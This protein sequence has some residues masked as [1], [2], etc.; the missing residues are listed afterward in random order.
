M[1][2]H[3]QLASRLITLLVILLSIA[4]I[5][6]LFQ[7]NKL[8]D[9]QRLIRQDYLEIG[10]ALKMLASSSN[11]QTEAARGYAATGDR[12]HLNTYRIGITET[13]VREHVFE[14]LREIG[15]QAAEM[16]ALEHGGRS[17]HALLELERQALDAASQGNHAGALAILYSPVYLSHKT[18]S[19]SAVDLATAILD[20]RLG[21]QIT[22]LES[23]IDQA[24]KLMLVTTTSSV[25]VIMLALLG[26]YERRVVNPVIRITRQTQRLL[27]GEHGVGF[28]H[29]KDPVEI[30]ELA[31]VLDDYHH[32]TVQLDAQRAEQQAILDTATSGIVLV[33]DD[34]IIKH[35]NHKLH[36][37]FDW[38][39]GSMP[40]LSTRIWYPDEAGWEAGGNPVYESIWQG[41]TSRREQQLIRRD[42]S[43]FWARLTSRAVDAS[44]RSRGVVSIIEDISTE[45]AAIEAMQQAREQ[46]EEAAR[47][48]A[49]FLANMS[50]EIRTP[51][52]AIIGMAHLA[53][54]TELTPRQRDYLRKIQ[55]SG[56]HL[57]GIIN[58]ILDFS[59]LEAG[60]MSIEH[61]RFELDPMLANV[62]NLVIEKCSS[63]GLELIVD[64]AGDVPPALLGDPLRIGQ[65]LVNYASNAIKFT[66]RGEVLIRV[67]AEESGSQDVL[68][69]FSVTDTGIGLSEAQCQR[70]FNSFEQADASTTRK[71][72]GT[73]LGLAL[74]KQLAE[75][76]GGEV[77]VES[78]PGRGSTFWFTVRLGRSEIGPRCLLPVPDLRGCRVLVV[79]DN[80]HAREVSSTLLRSMSFVTAEAASGT[81]A[82]TELQQAALAGEPYQLVLLDWNMPE[83]DGL[84]TART[85]SA[86][87]LAP[88]PRMIMVTAY[89][90]DNL[91][92]A[93]IEAGIE[94]ILVKPVTASQLFDTMM[95]V[96]GAT[97][98]GSSQAWPNSM[99]LAELAPIRGS[100]LLLVEDNELNQEVAA[101]LL[102]EAGLEV[103]IAANGAIALDK[104]AHGSYDLVLMDVQMPVMDGIAA[105][106]AIRQRPDCADLP[107]VA[108]TA[109]AMSD[110][111]EDCLA[112]GMNDHLAKPI[113]PAQLWEKLLQW[114][115]PHEATNPPGPTTGCARPGKA[116]PAC[117]LPDDIPGLDIPAGLARAMGREKLYLTLLEKFVS[118]HR[119]FAIQLDNALAQD[120]RETAE[121]LA[122]TLKGSSAQ[123]GANQLAASAE[124]L[125]SAIRAHAAANLIAPL[126]TETVQ[127]SAELVDSLLQLLPRR[128]PAAAAQIDKARLQEICR[129]LATLLAEDDFTSNQ[130]IDENAALLKQ[131][132]GDGFDSVAAASRSFD[133]S[134][135]LAQLEKAARQSGIVLH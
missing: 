111:R 107:I 128:T 81:A 112:A 66:E 63:K 37:M 57:L 116:E 87:E 5:G 2:I 75:L 19:S 110:D 9:Q 115:K 32:M 8:I 91:T 97:R 18:N 71:F 28:S 3:I 10:R 89:G 52:N 17:A 95:Q 41:E 38:P 58:D 35:G 114:I 121:R 82:I 73:G 54:M 24:Q 126:R 133:F 85:I 106:R 40:G 59:K 20:N 4:S 67:A 64:V 135:A 65:I 100:R 70:L 113:A 45:R 55:G 23:R 39:A 50:H 96:M 99:D 119:D 68:L 124:K 131:G 61:I 53:L 56:Q 31:K 80:E 127:G 88:P 25:L 76:M 51:M 134:E 42:G 16:T 15:V 77:G 105:T 86:L 60:K 69:R 26:F 12:N 102:R 49:N 74:S 79:D 44:D 1:R 125:E 7:V 27:G 83:T 13:R 129:H 132:L 122:H 94:A 29:A 101:G 47:T 84:E 11:R 72:G 103:D 78:A 93:A 22:W 109:N 92:Q 36:A 34:R 130:L 108:M 120:D 62:V 33:G 123:I 21:G 30:A 43:L 117:T 98:S 90:S 6:S 46:A 118:G 48:K 14:R 104:I